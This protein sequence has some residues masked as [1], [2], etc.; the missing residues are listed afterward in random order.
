MT[1][2]ALHTYVDKFNKHFL[3]GV[4]STY[5]YP[6]LRTSAGINLLN[7]LS[8]SLTATALQ[9][10]NRIAAALIVVYQRHSAKQNTMVVI[11]YVCA[12]KIPTTMV[13]ILHVCPC[14]ILTCDHVLATGS[15]L[16]PVKCLL[17]WLYREPCLGWQRGTKVPVCTTL[18]P[19][20]MIWQLG[21]WF[22]FLLLVSGVCVDCGIWLACGTY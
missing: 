4:I 12:C 13:D 2:K 19:V 9:A 17:R 21:G 11:L 18:H 10:R 6:P 3:F 15:L 14:K 7:G 8:G 5:F 22:L 16:W 1:T 20:S